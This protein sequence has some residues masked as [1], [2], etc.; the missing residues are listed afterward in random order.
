MKKLGNMLAAVAT[1][2][3]VIGAVAIALMMLHITADV[4]GKF[5]FNRPLPGTIPIVSQFYMVIATFLPLAMVER[6]NGHI[7]VEIIVTNFPDR[8]QDFIAM[9]ASALG[10]IIFGLLTWRA[11]IEAGRKYSVGTF[12][13]ENGHKILTWPTY[14][15]VP[16]GTALL[17]L[18][19]FY[20][21]AC[22]FTGHIDEANSSDDHATKGAA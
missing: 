18:V 1:A 22:Y 5:V 3:A 2:Y 12:S 8:L 21:L 7:S 6:A 20:K 15:I 4:I 14:Y 10:T 9:L 13:Y 11:L 19:L 16:I 17:T